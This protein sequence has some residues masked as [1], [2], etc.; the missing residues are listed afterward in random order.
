[1]AK[2]NINNNAMCDECTIIQWN[3]QLYKLHINS[4]RRN[5]SRIIIY[6]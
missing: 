3:V 5:R 1:M 2:K 6:C 4:N